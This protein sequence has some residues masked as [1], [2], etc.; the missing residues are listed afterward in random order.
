M[1]SLQID[2]KSLL[3]GMLFT[4]LLSLLFAFN[5]PSETPPTQ[6][7]KYQAVSSERGFLI[8]D[9]QTGEY[10]LDSEVN[11]V[12]KMTWIRGDFDSSFEAGKDKTK[13]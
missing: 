2:V 1:K 11:Y 7:G 12:G 4:C 10:I 8:L 9:T 13:N 5:G 6:L 3:I